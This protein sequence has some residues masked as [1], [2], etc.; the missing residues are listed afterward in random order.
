[1]DDT[2]KTYRVAGKG[3][4]SPSQLERWATDKAAK[5]IAKGGLGL[6]GIQGAIAGWILEELIGE[7]LK[8]EPDFRQ[9]DFAPKNSSGDMV[10]GIIFWFKLES[11]I[12]CT[13][14]ARE[15]AGEG[16]LDLAVLVRT[17]GGYTFKT[18]TDN[19][20][21][22]VGWAE[23]RFP[24]WKGQEIELQ[25]YDEDPG[26]HDAIAKFTLPSPYGY[27][28]L[29]VDG[30]TLGKIGFL[31][32]GDVALMREKCVQTRCGAVVSS[33]LVVTSVVEGSTA[34]TI[35]LQPGDVIEA[36]DEKLIADQN[37][38]VTAIGENSKPQVEL[39]IRR[40]KSFKTYSIKAGKIG[41]GT[42]VKYD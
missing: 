37:D 4:P 27:Y 5:E 18:I 7:A 32:K 1:M 42:E 2:G 29:K 9:L 38:L 11:G 21:K 40:G 16:A 39:R 30:A 25:V 17:Q 35:G 28:E 10:Y 14:A 20:D 22:V 24:W 8:G 12:P 19:K 41:I 34:A 26:Q 13:Q 33:H 6:G 3:E 15:G 23:L 36:Y 31:S